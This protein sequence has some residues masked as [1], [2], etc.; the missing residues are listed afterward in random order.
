MT[1]VMQTAHSQQQQQHQQQQQRQQLAI[2]VITIISKHNT[3]T[4]LFRHTTTY[5]IWHPVYKYMS[6]V[7]LSITNSLTESDIHKICQ[8]L[9]RFYINLL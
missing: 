1:Y 3:N 7:C 5:Y 9:C 4:S 2:V 6:L 8:D